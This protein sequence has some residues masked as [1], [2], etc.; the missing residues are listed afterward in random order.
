MRAIGIKRITAR[1]TLRIIGYN[2]SRAVHLI[3]T[4]KKKL[5]MI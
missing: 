1:V 2:L 4:Q 3:T 5:Q